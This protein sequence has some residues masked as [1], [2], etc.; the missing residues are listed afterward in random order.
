MVSRITV[1]WIFLCAVNRET[2]EFENSFVNFIKSRDRDLV[3]LVP[4]T[5]L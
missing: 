5:T 3:N 4:H 2:R 1:T